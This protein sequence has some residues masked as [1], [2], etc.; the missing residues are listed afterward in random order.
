MTGLRKDGT[1]FDYALHEVKQTS[2]SFHVEFLS[3]LLN[4][5]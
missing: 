1:M 5:A 2:L 4:E 3:T